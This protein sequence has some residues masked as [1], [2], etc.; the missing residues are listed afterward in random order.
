MRSSGQGKWG[1]VLLF[2]LLVPLVAG[3]ALRAG[4]PPPG[5]PWETDYW[6][7]RREA[8]RTGTPVFIYFTKT[9]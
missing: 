3:T 2:L 7:A 5:P 1:G 4:E 8:L 6:T 9:Y